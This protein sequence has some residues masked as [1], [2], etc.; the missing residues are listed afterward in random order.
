MLVY[1]STY[2]LLQHKHYYKRVLPK[3]PVLNMFILYTPTQTYT[4]RRV[5]NILSTTGVHTLYNNTKVNT[6]ACYQNSLSYLC[7]YPPKENKHDH[8]VLVRKCVVL[9]VYLPFTT[10]QT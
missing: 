6:K 10:T 4:Q 5:T 1:M 8:N 2:P 7:T 9:H 3:F